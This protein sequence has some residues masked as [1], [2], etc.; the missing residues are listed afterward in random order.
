MNG[1]NSEMVIWKWDKAAVH[2]TVSG[3]EESD[4]LKLLAAWKNNSDEEIKQRYFSRWSEIDKDVFPR[5]IKLRNIQIGE[6]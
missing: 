5:L 4:D 3:F 6:N 1:K 2:E